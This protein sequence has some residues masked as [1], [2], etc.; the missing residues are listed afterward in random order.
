[1][2]RDSFLR[3]RRAHAD[4]PTIRV[5][6]RMKLHSDPVTGSNR[7]TGYGSG[8][9]TVNEARITD[10]VVVT[11]TAVLEDWAPENF[12]DLPSACLRLL[13]ELEM[14]VAILG[15]GAS[16]QFPRADLVAKFA[17]RGIGLEIMDTAAACRTY[18]ILMAEGRT[19]A[20][21]LLPISD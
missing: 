20:A 12:S 13:D 19:V 16:Q 7:I 3:S 21:M 8:Y 5:T 14:E 2:R 1:M 17:S 10:S 9:V 11:P 18:N 15:T 6:E 4:T